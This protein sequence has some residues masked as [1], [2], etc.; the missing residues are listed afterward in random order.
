MEG[1]NS[2][3]YRL[4]YQRCLKVNKKISEH[5]SLDG[6]GSNCRRAHNKRILTTE[7]VYLSLFDI[8]LVASS[9]SHTLPQHQCAI[10]V[11]T[12]RNQEM[13][14]LQT[15]IAKGTWEGQHG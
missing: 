12:T 1:L 11:A 2:I 6:E 14:A 10:I 8:R 13:E 15:A 9:N 5:E 4:G 3:S 7:V